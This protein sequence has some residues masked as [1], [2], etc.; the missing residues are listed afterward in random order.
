MSGGGGD[1]AKT[2]DFWSTHTS[3]SSS[4]V[5][6]RAARNFVMEIGLGHR[7]RENSVRNYE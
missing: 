7:F 4:G 6:I 5:A 3:F 2:G 1:E